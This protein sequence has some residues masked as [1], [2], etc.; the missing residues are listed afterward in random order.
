MTR[1]KRPCTSILFMILT[2]EKSRQ[3]RKL[4]WRQNDGG[5]DAIYSGL[6]SSAPPLLRPSGMGNARFAQRRKARR[7]SLD[8]ATAREQALGVKGWRFSIES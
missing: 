2:P 6:D 3:L 1:Q 4:A 5:G 7:P 8:G